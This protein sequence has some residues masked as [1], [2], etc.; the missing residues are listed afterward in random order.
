MSGESAASVMYVSDRYFKVWAYTVSHCRLLLRSTRGSSAETRIDVHFSAVSS[1]LLRPYYDGLKIR[2]GREI[3]Y[4]EVERICGDRPMP[5]RLYV[6][7][8]DLTSFVVS[9]E[10]QWHED[11]G[12]HSDPSWF[13]HMVGTA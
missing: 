1:L 6:L 8:E 3:E 12:S 5:G 11:H 13:G 9:A 2:R 4:D 7:G 10:P